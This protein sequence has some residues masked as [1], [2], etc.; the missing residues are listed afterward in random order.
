M[1]PEAMDA[2]ISEQAQVQETL[3]ASDAWTLDDRLSFAMEALACPPPE[4]LMST[5]SGGEKRRVALCRLLIQEPDILLLD[6]PTNHLDAASV[7]WLEQHL[8]AYRGTVIAITHD[9]YFLD[10]VAG[11]IL[12]LDRGHGI[13]Y[14]GNY[15][16]WLEQ[17]QAR[18]GLEAKADSRRSKILER[19]LAWMK[20]SPKAR[21]SKSKARM[22]AYEQL[23]AQDQEQMGDELRLYIP[24]G[25]R[26][27]DLVIEARSVSKVFDDRVLYED[28]SFTIPPGAIVGIVGPNGAGKSTLFEMLCG[29]QTPDKGEIT[30]GQTVSLGYMRQGSQDWDDAKT[31]YELVSGGYDMI[32][33]GK[34]EVSAR[35]Y[36]ASFQFSGQDQQKT[37]GS[38]SG[39]ER[40]R[41]QLA[42]LLKEGANVLLLD[43]PTNDLDVNTLR[44]LED[45]LNNFAGCALVISHD[46]WFLDRIATHILAFEAGKVVWLEGSYQ[47]YEQVRVADTSK[48]YKGLRR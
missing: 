21:Q 7:S 31:I 39:G 47:D 16:G 18:L 48:R 36:V 44:A 14:K 9:R 2:L 35:G 10:N 6:E 24:P 1:T 20:L 34:R 25:P 37:I 26:L 42:M 23:L 45:A 43:E 28:L 30:T 13:P 19:E 17:K 38:L 5:L 12:E 11:W 33:L 15:S 3:D 32:T 46:R 22:N 29:A 40:H 27:G 41:L 4:R 8:K